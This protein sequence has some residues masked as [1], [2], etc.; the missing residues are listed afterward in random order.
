MLGELEEGDKNSKT[1]M[2]L[3]ETKRRNQDRV[4]HTDP[5]SGTYNSESEDVKWRRRTRY[6]CGIK[7]TFQAIIMQF[8][9]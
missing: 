2:I 9:H 7:E 6:D 8:E 3:A 4:I 5:W 1:C